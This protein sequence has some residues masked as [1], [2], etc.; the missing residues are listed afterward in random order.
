MNS[1]IG[2]SAA[3]GYF[4]NALRLGRLGHATLLSGPTGIGKHRLA[5]NVA[6]ALLCETG[7]EAACDRCPTCRLAESGNHPDLHDLA[8]AEGERHLGIEDVRVLQ[9]VAARTGFAGRRRVILL[10]PA[11]ALTEDAANALLKLLEEPP[12]HL[13]LL[14][15]T[16][17]PHR[18]P[19]TLR[20][21]CQTV[22]L[23]RLT[24][25]EVAAILRTETELPDADASLILRLAAGS[26]GTALRLARENAPAAL[27]EV[28]ELLTKGNEKVLAPM[29]EKR[30]DETLEERRERVRPLLDL[31]LVGMF[32]GRRSLAAAEA[33]LLHR[34]WLE[35]NA[36]IS[37]LADNLQ[38]MLSNG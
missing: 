38:V 22:R 17:R 34:E 26:P 20:S 2:H 18:L 21:R 25:A 32:D 16:T 11:D 23:S 9:D 6:K 7:K 31:L 37:L 36:N 35:E 1:I 33:I 5:R 13:Y 4:R 30:K 14:L 8:P 19:A 10:D 15:I 3:I 12:P 28:R 27:A 29:R 24:T